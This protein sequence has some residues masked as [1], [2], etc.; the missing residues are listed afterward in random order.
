M[1]EE[2]GK[3]MHSEK[4]AMEMMLW[5]H[6]TEEQQ[7]TIMTRFLDLKIKKKEMMISMMRDKIRM[8]EEKLDLLREIREMLKSGR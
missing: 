7:R 5:K 6:L 2:M 4:M 1:H 8:M 3:G